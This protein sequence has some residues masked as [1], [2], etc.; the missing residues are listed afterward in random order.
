MKSEIFDNVVEA[1]IMKIKQ[2]LTIKAKEYA[3]NDNR[4]HNFDRSA[5]ISGLIRE[6]A[7]WMFMVKHLVSVL[8]LIDDIEKGKLPKE[9]VLDEKI[10]DI[11]NYFIL[12]EASIT[13]RIIIDRSNYK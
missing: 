11:I 10:G 4:M 1:R 12:L 8:D 13:D 3:R 2:T 5:S 6:K 9:E 7:L